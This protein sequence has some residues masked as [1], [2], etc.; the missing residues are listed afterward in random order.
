[1]KT[2]RNLIIALAIV[3]FAGVANASPPQ[4]GAFWSFNNSD[5]VDP[6]TGAAQG[7]FSH[8]IS[9]NSPFNDGFW[10]NTTDD[11]YPVNDTFNSPN[12]GELVD[13][14]Q[15][16]GGTNPAGY[17]ASI[18][19]SDLV[20]DNG[21]TND[22]Q[23]N[24]WLSFQGTSTTGPIVGPDPTPF[25]GG[26]L[27]VTG[28]SNNGRTFTVEI[29]ELFNA[30]VGEFWEITQ[31]SWAQRGTSSGFNQR[32]ITAILEDG[33]RVAYETESG[34]LSS[35]WTGEFIDFQNGNSSYDNASTFGLSPLSEV[36]AV[37]FELLGTSTSNGNNRFDNIGIEVQ[38]VPEPASIALFGL[39]G[40]A[41]LRR[42]RV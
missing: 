3:A 13:P 36:V 7:I 24:N 28:Q 4:L 40:L 19:V 27:A 42:R 9:D 2:I 31:I 16:D 33:T 18:D 29:D 37:E 14:S 1:M 38:A 8:Q 20:G 21:V 17:G 12:P 23:N 30:P 34:T 11:L 32:N 10:D 35:T 26:S 5:D 22:T 39:G 15:Y 6:I 25:F 41:M